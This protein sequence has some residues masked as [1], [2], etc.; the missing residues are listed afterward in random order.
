MVDVILKVKPIKANRYVFRSLHNS[1]STWQIVSGSHAWFPPTDVYETDLDLVV[2][3]EIAGMRDGE[4]TVTLDDRLLLIQ[5]RR[6]SPR[7]DCAYHQLEIGYGKFQ[8]GV[9]LHKAIV[10][11]E[12]QATY[13]DGFLE[14][15]LP[16]RTPQH[17]E[18]KEE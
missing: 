10:A 5:G 13:Q 11:E 1:R 8:S 16:K 7:R 18:V 3:V 14:L 2:R 6:P 17:V 12:A 15:V 9:K 4:L